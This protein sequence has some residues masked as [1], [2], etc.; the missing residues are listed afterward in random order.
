[1]LAYVTKPTKRKEILEQGLG[2]TN[3]TKNVRRYIDPLLKEG[4]LDR[5]IKDR[6]NSPLQQYVT[7]GKGREMLKF[8]QF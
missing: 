8:H 3:H 1:M 5:T 4:L 7:T 2:M 6:P